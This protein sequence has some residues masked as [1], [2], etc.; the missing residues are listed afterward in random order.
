MSDTPNS[1]PTPNENR[2]SS[3]DP[4]DLDSESGAVG[5]PIPSESNESLLVEG[6]RLE[7][8]MT[9]GPWQIARGPNEHLWVDAPSDSAAQVFYHGDAAGIVWLRN[10]ASRL[11]AR[12]E[13]LTNALRDVLDTPQAPGTPE[14][15]REV[16]SVR[17]NARALLEGDDDGVA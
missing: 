3:S 12:I 1:K 10:N 17:G 4:L 8:G 16:S 11:L 2:F 7:A 9:A 6:K 14:M 5:A 15:G 13:E